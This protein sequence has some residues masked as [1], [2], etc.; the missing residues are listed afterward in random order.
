VPKQA[1]QPVMTLEDLLAVMRPPV[2][3]RSG[4]TVRVKA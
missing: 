1:G 3:G 2:T 4:N